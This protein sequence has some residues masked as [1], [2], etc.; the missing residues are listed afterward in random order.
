LLAAAGVATVFGG[1]SAATAG[2]YGK[3]VIDD[4]AP[5][6]SAWTFC[7]TFNK[8]YFYK[9]DGFVKSARFLG[10]YQGQFISQQEDVNDTLNNGY[11]EYQ[12]RRFR[13][14]FEVE[15]ANDLT[16]YTEANIADGRELTQ[17]RFINDFQDF[18][19]EWEPSDDLLVRI[20]KQKQHITREDVESSKRIK[21]VERSAIVNEIA[22]A[23]AWGAVVEFQTGEFRHEIGGWLYGGHR[24]DP[25][26]VDFSSNGGFNY[27]VAYPV[28]DTTT[29]HFDYVYADNGGG[30]FATEGDAATGFGPNYEHAFALGAEVEAGRFQMIT[31]VIV[32]LNRTESGALGRAGSIP[33][34]NDTWGFY[35][36]PSYDITEKLEAVFR[37]AYMDEGQEQRTQRFPTRQRVENY[38][39]VYAGLQYFICGEKLKLMGGYEYASGDIF[40]SNNDV[41]GGSWQLA[42]RSYW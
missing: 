7:D 12:H 40:D 33:P 30:N 6:E 2:D 38:H 10:R 25:N 42:V 8:M 32:A 9:G 14:G 3:V 22:G 18:Y 27:N 39:T 16:F 26:W 15:L 35:V 1:V 20:G 36:Q 5:I 34:G 23:R 19:I 17:D 11:H 31:D 4:K 24:A 29:L 21:S 41:S 13:L 37:Y 28:S